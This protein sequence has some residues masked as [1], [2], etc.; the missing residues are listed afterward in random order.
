M[1]PDILVDEDIIVDAKWKALKPEETTAGVEQSDVYQML[2]YERA[3]KARRLVLIYPWFEGVEKSGVFRRW[4]VPETRTAF[5][6][7]Y[8]RHRHTAM[9]ELSATGDIRGTLTEL[10]IAGIGDRS[11]RGVVD[12]PA[13]PAYA[14]EV[15][16]LGR[17]PML[18]AGG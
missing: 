15:S 11:S 6:N 14:G 7:P 10:R 8:G 3:Y 9:R 5:R 12:S 1:Q 4:H 2:A 16:P 18:P 13:V 17:H